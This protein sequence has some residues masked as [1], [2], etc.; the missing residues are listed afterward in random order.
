MRQICNLSFCRGINFTCEESMEVKIEIH[1]QILKSYL[2]LTKHM[3]N[4]SMLYYD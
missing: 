2:N 3:D 4:L 1:E